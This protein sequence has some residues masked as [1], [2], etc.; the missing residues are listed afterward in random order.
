M[1][2]YCWPELTTDGK[3]LQSRLMDEYRRYADILKVLLQ[4]QPERARAR[5]RRCRLRRRRY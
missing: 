5:P 3:R 2:P 1:H 4:G